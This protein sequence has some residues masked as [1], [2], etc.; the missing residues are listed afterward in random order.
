MKILNYTLI[1]LLTVSLIGCKK[2]G[3]T[4]ESGKDSLTA[5]KIL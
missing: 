5:K 4:N 1:S 2:D 3:K